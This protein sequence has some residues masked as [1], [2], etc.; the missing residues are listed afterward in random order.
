TILAD[1]E[2]FLGNRASAWTQI[3]DVLARVQ[4][5]NVSR[6]NYHL[7]IAAT[8]SLGEHLPEA[9]LEFQ[10]ARVRLADSPRSRAEAFLQRARTLVI[11][12]D[13]EA[14]LA[15]LARADVAAE[16]LD[17]ESLRQRNV[18]DI[19]IARAELLSRTDCSRAIDYATAALGYVEHADP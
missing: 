12:G 15:D 19:R 8:L 10:N 6:R 11:L 2:W 4:A 1:A 16:H 13:N 14:S 3:G 17:D 18:A 9:A 5:A 7:A